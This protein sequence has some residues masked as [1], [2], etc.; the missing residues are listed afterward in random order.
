MADKKQT[1]IES[2]IDLLAGVVYTLDLQRHVNCVILRNPSTTNDIKISRRSDVTAVA[3]YETIASVDG[4]GFLVRP[5]AMDKV[6]LISA[7][8]IAGV[9]V[10]QVWT[11]APL[12]IIQNMTKPSAAD[13]NV[14]A[15]V[16]LKAAELNIAAVT[17]NLGVTV[18]TALPAGGNNIGDVD[19]LSLPPLPAGTNNIGDVD[20]LTLPALAAGTNIIGKVNLSG[21]ATLTHTTVTAGLASGAALAANAN[22]KYALLFN[23]SNTDIY[24]K[25]HSAAVLNEGIRIPIGG[26]YEMSNVLGNLDT[27]A[28]NCI[29]SAAGK[30]LLVT[31]GA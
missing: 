29:C 7:A 12:N 31:E 4:W 5:F 30:T 11:D 2:S 19:V 24:I 21:A 8:N 16:G 23:D 18:A 10:A 13:V 3:N 6:Y 20:V 27:R 9:V 26:S 17:K 15:T 1:W 25:V 22:R 28:I 14:T